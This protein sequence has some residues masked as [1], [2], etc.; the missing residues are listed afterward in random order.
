MTFGD[1]HNVHLTGPGGI[2]RAIAICN[3]E[4]DPNL[5][6]FSTQ[7]LPLDRRLLD[8][9]VA[10]AMS[11]IDSRFEMARSTAAGSIQALEMEPSFSITSSPPDSKT[12]TPS[13]ND[14]MTFEEL[15]Q[16]YS[17]RAAQVKKANHSAPQTVEQL[18][19]AGRPQP[20][21]TPPATAS[22]P[23]LQSPSE[24]EEGEVVD[25]FNIELDHDTLNSPEEAIKVTDAPDAPN[26]KAA[27][28]SDSP[29]YG[30]ILSEDTSEYNGQVTSLLNDVVFN[31]LY[32]GLQASKTLLTKADT[33]HDRKNKTGDVQNLIQACI[34][35]LRKRQL[36][37]LS[38]GIRAVLDMTSEQQQNWKKEGKLFLELVTEKRHYE[39]ESAIRAAVSPPKSEALPSDNTAF[40]AQRAKAAVSER[41]QPLDRQGRTPAKVPLGPAAWVR[42]KTASKPM[43]APAFTSQKKSDSAARIP[44]PSRNSES[45]QSRNSAEINSPP[46][47]QTFSSPSKFNAGQPPTAK[48][49]ISSRLTSLKTSLR[50][51]SKFSIVPNVQKSPITFLRKPRHRWLKK[52]GLMLKKIAEKGRKIIHRSASQIQQP[53]EFKEN[54]DPRRG[55]NNNQLDPEYEFVQNRT[56]SVHPP[57]NHDPLSTYDRLHQPYTPKQSRY[58][59]IEDDPSYNP[60]YDY[61]Y[62]YEPP[63]T[64][65]LAV[66]HE[67]PSSRNIYGNAM[68]SRQ[69]LYQDEFIYDS[70]HSPYPRGSNAILRGV[71]AVSRREND[72]IEIDN[73][74]LQT[75]KPHVGPARRIQ[76][77]RENFHTDI[78]NR[79]NSLSARPFRRPVAIGRE[80]K[81]ESPLQSM[82]GPPKDDK[83]KEL[84]FRAGG[85]YYRPTYRHP[86]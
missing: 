33:V 45:F 18:Q 58:A 52:H 51:Q 12:L 11:A 62:D 29:Y 36:A 23:V 8:A 53:I 77:S 5:R 81:H 34:D 15:I 82:H 50:P 32:H 75:R 39:Q 56:S 38:L 72:M 67:T 19:G 70:R 16:K 68:T 73:Y 47:G 22:N 20:P 83:R 57:A 86:Y 69:P 3:L 2:G 37:V 65:R 49:F 28:S 24:V 10:K 85:D 78:P 42:A 40:T 59:D 54:S 46:K 41:P 9:S 1:I 21:Q 60:E 43:L 17:N 74:K 79:R 55:P 27:A 30:H 80:E 25:D 14:D 66:R 84:R 64:R 44:R 26:E 35:H 76:H 48:S 61:D 13:S 31:N 63:R 6:P 71:D 7:D 4:I